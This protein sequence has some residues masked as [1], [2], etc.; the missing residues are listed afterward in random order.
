MDERI[1][2]LKEDGDAVKKTMDTNRTKLDAKNFKQA[3]Y[4]SFTSAQLNLDLKDK[5]QSKAEELAISATTEKNNTKQEAADLIVLQQLTA[6]Q[7]V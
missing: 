3:K 2:H 1:E 4:D 7:S 6:L 5:E